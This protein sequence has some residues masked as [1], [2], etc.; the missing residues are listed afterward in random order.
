MA[1]ISKIKLSGSTDGQPIPVTGTA[2]G[3]A[4][5]IHTASATSLDETLLHASNI[6]TVDHVL[7]I[8]FGSSTGTDVNVQT[9]PAKD[10]AYI[11]IPGFVLTNSKVVKAFADLA[12]KVNIIGF[13]NRITM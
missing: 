13:V 6:D 7:T 12:S 1:T 11:V 2:T 3:S 4:N 9:I 5:T 8:E 10:G